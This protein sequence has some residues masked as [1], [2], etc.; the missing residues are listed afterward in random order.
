MV[1]HAANVQ[2]YHG[3]RLVFTR[4]SQS[5]WQRLVKFW[6]DAIYKGD[7]NLRD[8]LKLTFGWDLEVVTRDRNQTGFQPLPHR[9][10]V[11]R[12]FAWL[13]RNR[14]LSKDYELLPRHSETWLYAAMSFL[15]TRRLAL[16]S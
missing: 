2:D 3:A 8:W 15:L 10:V 1:V 14:R 12:T 7:R 13:G 4:L 6:A 16:N 9:W 11:E 5:Q